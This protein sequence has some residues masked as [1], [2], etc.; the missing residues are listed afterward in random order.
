[1][2]NITKIL[3]FGNISFNGFIYKIHMGLTLIINK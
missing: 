1:M 3:V 2:R